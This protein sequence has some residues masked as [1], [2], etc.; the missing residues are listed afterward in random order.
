VVEI[1][2]YLTAPH[3]SS[4]IPLTTDHF[5]VDALAEH[6]YAVLRDLDPEISEKEFLNLEYMDWKSGGDTNFA[7][8]ATADGNLDC[9]GFWK[10]GDEKPDKG[11]Q[12]TT[13]A[14]QCPSLVACV[15]E[16]GADF[17]RVRVIRLAPQSY[18]EALRQIHR[19]DNNRFNP[20]DQGWVVRQWIEL[21]DNPGAFMILMEQGPDG[22]PDASTEVRI[23]FHRNVRVVVDT[24]RL[25][26]VVCNPSPTM[27]YALITSFESSPALADWIF[28]NRC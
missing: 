19:D 4:D 15:E 3:W 12:W 18:E 20:E 14:E 11:G 23:P 2:D 10:P 24:Q 26:H 8:I 17:G 27:R 1:S 25:W 13:N 22:L 28:A 9:R 21:T 6:G 16:V 7:P 5:R